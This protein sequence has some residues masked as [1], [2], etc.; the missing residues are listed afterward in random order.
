MRGCVCRLDWDRT[1]RLEEVFDGGAVPPDDRRLKA[2]KLSERKR[3]RE[4][5]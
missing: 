5:K 2:R 1:G 3:R 4:C